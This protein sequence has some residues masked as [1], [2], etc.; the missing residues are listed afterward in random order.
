M[1]SLNRLLLL[2]ADG[3]LSFPEA[4]GPVVLWTPSCDVGRITPPNPG[5]LRS[6]HDLPRAAVAFPRDH[7]DSLLLDWVKE[8]RLVDFGRSIPGGDPGRVWKSRVGD[9]YNCIFQINS[10][11]ASNWSTF[12]Q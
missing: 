2:L 4:I 6:G 11:N 9:Y 12:L 8:P 7:S 1:A 10:N 5:E 3:S